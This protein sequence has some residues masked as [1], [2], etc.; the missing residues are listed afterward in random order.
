[1]HVTALGQALLAELTTGEVREMLPAKLERFSENTI[2]DLDDLVTEL[3]E[4]RNRGWALE[5]EQGAIGASAWHRR[6]LPDPATEAL[7]VS[8]PAEAAS[9]PGEL[10]R[11]GWRAGEAASAWARELSGGG[12]S[13][14][15]RNR[16]ARDR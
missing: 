11:I 2:V 9:Y 14:T 1:M 10:G 3:S 12:G 7:T 5:R 8:T 15:R 13:L 4:V 16:W 6:A